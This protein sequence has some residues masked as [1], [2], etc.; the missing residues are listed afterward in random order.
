MSLLFR[1]SRSPLLT[2]EPDQQKYFI[3]FLGPHF[4][5]AIIIHQ[6]DDYETEEQFMSL[7]RLDKSSKS[8]GL[9]KNKNSGF[10]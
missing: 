9:H 2:P 6:N 10:D 5:F 8:F 3:S 1:D 4:V 7:S